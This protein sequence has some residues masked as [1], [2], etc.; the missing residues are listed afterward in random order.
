MG[1]PVSSRGTMLDKCGLPVIANPKSLILDDSSLQIIGSFV[2]I[3][4][5]YHPLPSSQ[6][7][8]TLVSTLLTA[9]SH[10]A[11]KE[12]ANAPIDGILAGKAIRI[13]SYWTATGHFS[14]SFFVQKWR[15]DVDVHR[16]KALSQIS[17]NLDRCP[18]Q[19]FMRLWPSNLWSRLTEIISNLMASM[20][21][22]DIFISESNIRIAQLP[23]S[24]VAVPG[25]NTAV[26]ISFAHP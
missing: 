15:D 14:V 4:I 8:F 13:S 3:T 12:V 22:L 1:D 23:T 6:R 11:F 21:I 17:V 7:L 19:P 18:A 5:Q 16:C 24:G 10:S 20:D 26:Q 9:P 25:P 2:A